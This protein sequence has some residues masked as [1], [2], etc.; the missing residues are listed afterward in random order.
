VVSSQTTVTYQWRKNGTNIPY[1]NK[2]IYVISNFKMSDQGVYSVT[3]VNAGGSVTSSNATLTVL[4]PP[5]ITMQPQSQAVQNN[6]TVSFSVIANSAVPPGYQWSLNGTALA[7]ATS[8][9]LTVYGVHSGDAG[10]YSVVV[11]NYAGSVTSAVAVLTM[12]AP[13]YILTQPQSQTVVLGQ[14]ASFSVGAIGLAPVTYQWSLNGT[15]LPNA[16]NSTL[17]LTSVN[18]NNAGSYQVVLANNQGSVTSSNATLTVLSPPVITTQPQSQGVAQGQNVSFSVVSGGTAPFTYQWYLNGSSLGGGNGAQTATYSLNS[19]GTGNAGNYTVVITNSYGSVT[20]AVATLTV[21]VLPGI[22]TQ[23][24]NHSVLQGTNVSFFVVTNNNGTPPFSYQWN[25]NGTNVVNGPYISGTTNATLTLSNVQPAQAG[26]VFVVITNNAGS[27]TSSVVTLTVNVPATITNQPQSLTVTQGQ[28]ATFSV[29]A[30]GTPNLQY[31]W[32]FNGTKMGGGSTNATLTQSGA[33]TNNAGSYFVVVKN[34]Y[35]TVTSA[36]VNLTVLVP[37]WI[38]TQPASLGVTLGQSASFSVGAFG[39]A[40]LTYQWSYNGTNTV[41]GPNV[42]GSTSNTLTL[43]NVQTNQS[44]NYAVLVANNWGSVT[45]SNATLTVYIPPTITAQPMSLTLLQGQNAAFSVGASGSTP[46]TY[47]WYFNGF[48]Q[49]GA[50]SNPTNTINNVDASKAGNYSVV[51]SNPGGSLTSSVAILTVYGIQQQ[52]NNQTVTLGQNASFS[53]VTFGPT[54]GYQWFF[55]SAALSGATN[56]SLNLTSAQTNQA[57]NYL[58]V[59]ATPV[60]SITSQVAT[61]TVNVPAFITSQPTSL[62]VTQGQ[63]AAFTVGASGTPTISYKW[64]FNGAKMGGGSTSAT[65]TQTGANTNNAGSYYVVVK[66][67]WGMVTSAVATL[68]VY[69]A[70]SITSQPVNQTVLRGQNATFSV[71]MNSSGTQPF[72]Y[73]WNVNGV[74]PTWATN[75]SLTITNAQTTD[76]GSY[77]VVVTNLGGSVTS[78]TKTLTVNVPAGIATQPQSVATNQG[79]NVS[80]TVMAIGSGALNYQWYFNGVIRTSNGTS[81]TYSLT[82]VQPNTA[83]SYTVVVNNNWGTV[84]STP[85]ILTVYVPPTFAP[86]PGNQTVVQGQTATFTSGANG[87]SPF[88]FQWYF[89]GTN[90]TDGPDISGSLTNILTLSNVSSNTAGNYTV[91]VTNLGGIATSHVAT[92]TVN[93]PA[94]ITS[95]PTS[96]TVTQGQTVSFSVGAAGDAPLSYQWSYNGT[97]TVD[98]PNISGS[99][100][101]VLTLSNVQTNQAGNYAV[102]VVNNWGSVVSSNATLTVYLPPGITTQPVSQTVSVG[103]T[104]SFNVAA[105]GTGPLF[106]QWWFQGATVAGATNVSLTLTN[107][108]MSQAG[109]YTV[110]VTNLAGSVTSTQ[111]ILTVTNPV[112]TLSQPGGTTMTSTGYTFQISVPVGVT[113][114]VLASTNLLNWVPIA[115]NVAASASVAITDASATNYSNRYYEVMLP[116]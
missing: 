25:V 45:S 87:T 61:L 110:V 55:N 112:I 99:V 65:L 90:L 97:N 57:G 6:D 16:T 13:P 111:A 21:Y 38:A 75:S 107:A 92:L 67:N 3:A 42:S 108:P 103:Q 2:S 70:P 29:G 14:N 88:S 48:Q 66:N 74:N 84:T 89:N 36:V 18:T 50:S 77:Y 104:A 1:S 71:T 41:D 85:A 60:G 114:V 58:V 34:N 96:L 35:G 12:D 22:Q 31:Q 76:A 106:Y 54:P 68:T 23:P 105:T 46:F 100:S 28:A 69:V 79:N 59:I 53:V 94:F 93:I 91:V 101:N 10:N 11:T 27:I 33:G 115:T 15:N 9:T 113:Y 64:Y 49:G 62:T 40:P 52:P 73:Q 37:A 56:A 30:I 80:F 7:G 8:S 44:G 82:N 43:F 78:Q 47:Q 83:G 4:V 26:N 39:D 32:Y 116:Q 17:T 81:A 51:V 98:G 72:S 24:Q 95:Q 20:S 102:T 63:T 19:V 109:S 5:T 86:Q